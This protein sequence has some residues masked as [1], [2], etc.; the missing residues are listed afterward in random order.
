MNYSIDKLIQSKDGFKIDVPMS[1][2]SASTFILENIFF[3]VD[4]WKLKPESKA[5]LE[6]LFDFLVNNPL[7]KVELSGHTDS[8]G[9]ENDNQILSENR[10]KAVVDWLLNKDIE[11]N[12]MTFVGYGELK[13]IVPNNSSENKAKNRRTELTIK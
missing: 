7:L 5:E 2:I 1:K 10:A 3:D 13:P 12:R 9:N 11:V 4:S 6:E 8:D